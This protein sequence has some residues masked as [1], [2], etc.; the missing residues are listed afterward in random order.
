MYRG[1]TIYGLFVDRER[2]FFGCKNSGG[3]GDPR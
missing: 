3:G 2:A 1:S